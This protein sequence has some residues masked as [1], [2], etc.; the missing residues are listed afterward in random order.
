MNFP[1]LQIV[2]NPANCQTNV[3]VFKPSFAKLFIKLRRQNIAIKMSSSKFLQTRSPKLLHKIVFK[4]LN[5]HKITFTIKIWLDHQTSS[6]IIPHV[7][8]FQTINFTNQ[9]DFKNLRPF[10]I[11]FTNFVTQNLHKI[12]VKIFTKPS[13]SATYLNPLDHKLL[14]NSTIYPPASK[15][16]H[17][18]IRYSNVVKTSKILPKYSLPNVL[19]K[20]N[21]FS[22]KYRPTP[23]C[24][25]VYTTN[26]VFVPYF[27]HTH[28]WPLPINFLYSTLPCML[29][30]PMCPIFHSMCS[31][32]ALHALT[33][34]ALPL[35]FCCR[36][37]S[38]VWLLSLLMGSV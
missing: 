12:V 31:I 18:K 25:S 29:R 22:T 26:D 11:T 35:T 20:I 13:K 32:N 10:T 3:Y 21:Y 30:V 27:P 14:S 33:S 7:N 17:P 8:V 37:Y 4:M 24:S 23:F 2:H 15:P 34:H 9:I 28:E 38:W 6:K 1:P 19:T 36:C 16:F 5:L